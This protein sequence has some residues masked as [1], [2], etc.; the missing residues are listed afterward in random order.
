M[1]VSKN[2]L[3]NQNNIYFNFNSKLYSK[4]YGPNLCVFYHKWSWTLP[5]RVRK[6]YFHICIASPYKNFS[7]AVSNYHAGQNC[8]VVCGDVV[9]IIEKKILNLHYIYMLVAY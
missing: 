5:A 1:D 4:T 9:M 6:T 8:H 7:V 3:R 2:L